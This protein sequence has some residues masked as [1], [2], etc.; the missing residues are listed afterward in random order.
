MATLAVFAPLLLLAGFGRPNALDREVTAI[1]NHALLTQSPFLLVDSARAAAAARLEQFHVPV[2]IVMV[3]LQ[4]GALAWFWNSGNSARL[5]DYLRSLMRSEFAVRFCFGAL[6]ALVD[7]TA[8]FIPQALQYRF[9]RIMVLTE[10][11]FRTWLVHWIVGTLVSMVLAGLA[12]AIVLWLADRTHQW[13]LYTIAGV[14]GFTLL[15]S[16]VYPFTIAPLTEHFTPLQATRT[17]NADILRLEQR[18]GIHVP[19]IEVQVAH[20]TH[21]GYG[22]VLGWGGTQRAV[23]SDT[24]LAGA[25]EREVRFLVARSLAWVAANSGLHVALVQGA[26]L[27]IGVALAVFIS[28]RIGFRRDDDPVS[29]LAL[30]GALMGCVYLIALPFYNSY[31]RNLDIATDQA[32]IAITGD[33][34]S[35]IRL[36]IRRADQALAPVC[37]TPI[38][39]WY[40]DVHPSVGQQISLLQGRPDVCAR[41]R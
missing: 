8:A 24:I 19:F 25:T 13:Y 20:S 2:W 3:A 33:P 1:S 37:S 15:V 21:V 30:L 5:R 17:L 35:A 22:Y 18:T 29:R 10:L 38:A 11:L 4:I 41:N 12:A 23:L 14:I 26:F 28:D 36:E 6:L 31:S 40:F 7:R 34:V 27:V 32:A 9:M 16:Y 39:H